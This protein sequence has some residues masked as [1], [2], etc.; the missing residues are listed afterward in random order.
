MTT[1]ITFEPIATE[2]SPMQ[3]ASELVD[4]EIKLKD[5][6]AKIKGIKENLLGVMKETDTLSLKTGSY[7]IYRTKRVNTKVLSVDRLKEEL[8]K[9]DIPYY[10]QEVFAPSMNKVF[11]ELAKSNQ[12]IYDNGMPGLAVS[13]TEFVG[14]LVTKK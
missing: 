13:E 14:I 1:D 5:L 6:E 3:Q 8:D 12:D 2:V 4:L 9:R 7:T 11:R 10:T